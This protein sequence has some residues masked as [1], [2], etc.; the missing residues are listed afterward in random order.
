MATEQ[1]DMTEKFSPAQIARNFKVKVNKVLGW[2]NSGEL[3]AVNCA[4]N[5][6]GVPR[7]KVSAAALADFQRRRQSAQPAPPPTRRRRRTEQVKDYFQ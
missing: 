5:V 7:W 3:I 6:G 2:I 1:L 4:T